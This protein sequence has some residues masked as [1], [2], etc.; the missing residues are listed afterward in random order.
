MITQGTDATDALLVYE[1]NSK[2]RGSGMEIGL[3]GK[4]IHGVNGRMSY[5]FQSARDEETMQVLSNSPRHLFQMAVNV[6]FYR[7]IAQAGLS[8]RYLGS[9]RTQSGG[10]VAGYGTTDINFCSKKFW[11]TFAFSA[12]I[13]NIFNTR[14]SDPGSDE[15]RQQAIA[16]DGRTFRFALEILKRK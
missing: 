4:N 8:F 10:I 16:Q 1:N 13:Y 15:H 2:V 12:G 7:D 11:R 3:E 6:P 5:S 14:Y 9:R